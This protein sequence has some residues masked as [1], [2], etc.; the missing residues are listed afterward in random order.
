MKLENKIAF[1]SAAGRGIGKAIAKGLAAEGATVVV[2]SYSEETAAGTAD[3]IKKGG[4]KAVPMP[5]DATDPET[6]LALV[7]RIIDEFG[8]IDVLVNNI[9]AAPKEAPEISNNALGKTE[10]LWNAMYRQN[11]L[12]TV[13]MT[14]AVSKEMKRQTEGKI[15]NISSIA[16]INSFP[17]KTLSNLVHP[18]YGAMKAALLSYTKNCAEL[19]GPFN[20]NVN[21]VC[22]GIVYTDAWQGNAANLIR[23]SP[24]FQGSDPRKWFEGIFSDDHPDYFDR[25]PLKR[26]QS[27]E[28]MSNAVLFL[29]SQ[30][31][32][33]VTGQTLIVDGGMFKI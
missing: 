31:S 2:N 20:I 28:D 16:G 3:D 7:D 17:P 25:T 27:V 13:L 18:S 22:P 15:V 11:L 12:P 5:G 23:Y 30:D 32:M 4:G 21:A 10:G 9:G 1:V 19:Y 8:R 14:E 33:N 6:I 24:E 29:V 26:E